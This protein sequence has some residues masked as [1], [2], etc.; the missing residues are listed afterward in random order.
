[1]LQ[2]HTYGN[3]LGFDCNMLFP[4]IV[5]DITS[6]MTSGKNDRTCKDLLLKSFSLSLLCHHARHPVARC[7]QARHAR[8]KMYL[9]ATTQNGVSHVLYDTRKLV[10]SDM[11]M[12]I[13]QNCGGRSMLTEHIQNLLH[14]ATLL[15][16][17]IE[18]T[19]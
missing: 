5:I 8:L 18:L 3:A 15:R 9:A 7:Q 17:S 16:S 13:T 4:Q 12:S 6:R 11:R 1:M 10:G 19:I 2:A 14:T